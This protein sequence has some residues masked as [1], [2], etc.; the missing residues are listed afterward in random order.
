MSARMVCR[1]LLALLLV[2]PWTATLSVAGE[3]RAD[4]DAESFLKSYCLKCHQGE[5]PKAGVNLAKLA[6]TQAIAADPKTWA[7]VL[8]LV[9]DSA[10]P[11]VSSEAPPP[12]QREQF[13]AWVKQTLLEVVRAGGPKPG[14]APLR[15]LNR[16]EYG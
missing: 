16:T 8:H 5:K 12:Q 15:R 11:P 2:T 6:P 13:V 9:R 3:P 7:T 4:G 1:S 14:P 10:M